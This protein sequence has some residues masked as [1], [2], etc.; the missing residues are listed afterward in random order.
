MAS[1]DSC[2]KIVHFY[3]ACTMIRQRILWMK[4][5]PSKWHQVWGARHYLAGYLSYQFSEI[6]SHPRQAALNTHK[7]QVDRPRSLTLT[8]YECWTETLL[9]ISMVGLLRDSCRG[10]LIVAVQY[11]WSYLA[12]LKVCLEGFEDIRKEIGQIFKFLGK[13]AWK[14]K[15][16]AH[17]IQKH[18]V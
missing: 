5:M 4:Y 18:L 11:K 16:H 17:N 9:D 6:A 12:G 15:F 10:V 3:M 1:T 14:I 7:R 8:Y 13:E 2:H